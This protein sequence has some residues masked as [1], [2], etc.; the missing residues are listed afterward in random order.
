M[1]EERARNPYLAMPSESPTKVLAIPNIILQRKIHT[2]TPPA[3]YKTRLFF[4]QNASTCKP[5]ASRYL[6]K[7]ELTAFTGL[8]TTF[9]AKLPSTFRNPELLVETNLNANAKLAFF[10]RGK[11]KG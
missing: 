10:T 8:S 6:A 4:F 3:P 2:N 9:L 5:I 7:L 1:A 11:P